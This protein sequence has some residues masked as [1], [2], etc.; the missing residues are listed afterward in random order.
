MTPDLCPTPTPSP[1][2]PHWRSRLISRGMVFCLVGF[3]LSALF[4]QAL[5]ALVFLAGS[6]LAIA[7]ALLQNRGGVTEVRAAVREAGYD[8]KK[9]CRC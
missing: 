7:A 2:T 5:P 4:G 6:A 1:T 8:P 9:G 3:L